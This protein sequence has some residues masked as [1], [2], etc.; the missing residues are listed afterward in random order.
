MRKIRIAAWI[1]LLIFVGFLRENTFIY[2]NGLLYYKYYHLPSQINPAYLSFTNSWDYNQLYYFKWILTPAFTILFWALQYFLLKR[3]FT[4][5]KFRRW[6]GVFYLYLFLLSGLA[7]GI[8]MIANANQTGYKFS[9]IFMGILQSPIPCMILI[10]IS[11]FQELN[12][13]KE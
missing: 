2:L 8:G 5:K 1:A 9:R 13:S 11:Y 10:P 4:E 3:L 12:K 7:F 6:L